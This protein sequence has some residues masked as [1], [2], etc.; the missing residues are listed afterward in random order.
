MVTLEVIQSSDGMSSPLYLTAVTITAVAVITDTGGGLVPAPSPD[1]IFEVGFNMGLQGTFTKPEDFL[2]YLFGEFIEMLEYGMS[3]GGDL[4]LGMVQDIK[5]S[6]EYLKPYMLHTGLI[7][8]TLHDALLEVEMRG[9]FMSP[10]EKSM[11]IEGTKNVENL[12]LLLMML[13]EQ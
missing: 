10:M 1:N 5:M 8:D 12:L 2:I 3:L 11:S 13:S 4:I 9:T 6:G 7:G